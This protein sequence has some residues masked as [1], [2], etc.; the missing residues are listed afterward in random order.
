MSARRRP[1]SEH[2]RASLRRLLRLPARQPQPGG[3]K[4]ATEWERAA[5]ARL[6]HIE[7]QLASQNRLLFFTLVSIVAELLYRVT[8]PP[9][10]P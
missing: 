9:G 7:Q 8:L 1:G 3:P 5:E 10:A 2:L 4:P 6:S